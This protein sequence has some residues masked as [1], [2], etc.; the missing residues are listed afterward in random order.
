[1]NISKIK[2]SLI[3]VVLSAA[4]LWASDILVRNGHLL[5][6]QSQPGNAYV[7]TLSIRNTSDAPLAIHLSL[8]DAVL[9]SGQEIRFR[10][11]GS[12]A[13]SNG[14]WIH[15]DRSD[16]T[17][18]PQQTE[19]ITYSVRIP[20]TSASGSYWS[21]IRI[22]NAGDDPSKD[23]ETEVLVV[24]HVGEGQG[25]L[26]IVE[27]YLS[28]AGESLTADI[29][30]SNTG[31]RLIQPRL[32]VDLYDIDDTHIRRFDAAGALV[33]PGATTVTQIPLEGL[34]LGQYKAI[35]VGKYSSEKLSAD[36]DHTMTFVQHIAPFTVSVNRDKELVVQGQKSKPAPVQT[37]AAY[38]VELLKANRK[39]VEKQRAEALNQF[40]SKGLTPLSED[41]GQML[42]QEQTSLRAPKT[43]STERAEDGSTNPG[44]TT[45][46]IA[47]NAATQ[48]GVG[49]KITK[50]EREE[51]TKADIVTENKRYVVKKGDWLS[52]IALRYYGDMMKYPAIYEANRDIIRDPDLIYPGQK[53]DI[54]DISAAEKLIAEIGG[55]AHKNIV[56]VGDALSNIWRDAGEEKLASMSAIASVASIAERSESDH[57][58]F[59]TRM[60]SVPP[61]SKLYRI[62][63]MSEDRIKMP[64]PLSFR[65]FS[66]ASGSLTCFGL[67]PSPSSLIRTSR[68]VS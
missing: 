7:G 37:T 67:K 14:N 31:N 68:L 32:W 30:V 55:S 46:D 8:A 13:R 57:L 63:S 17:V 15:L 10:P 56:D 62:S 5:E 29:L 52:K 64:R 6:Q 12:M 16:L 36:L 58:Q 22:S 1:M 21:A 44:A 20:S 47:A 23:I 27:S 3:L 39:R 34:K 51:P 66:G 9:D 2:T 48:P 65:R 26:E 38:E 54:P 4:Q 25:R 49:E 35:V 53:L 24:T 61:C 28:S 59:L 19:H 43:E 50:P 18:L 41:A 33:F 42:P 45:D 40:A 11:R 60:I